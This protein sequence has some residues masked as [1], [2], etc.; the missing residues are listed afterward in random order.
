[1]WYKLYVVVS[2][3]SSDY[4]LKRK[5]PRFYDDRER[6]ATATLV[7]DHETALLYLTREAALSAATLLNSSNSDPEINYEVQGLK[8]SWAEEE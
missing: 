3:P 5:G 7:G 1:M 8:L 4:W 2:V 6:L